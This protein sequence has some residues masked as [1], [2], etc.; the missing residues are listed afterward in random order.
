MTR[1][2]P[3]QKNLVNKLLS[4]QDVSGTNAVDI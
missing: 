4:Y 2:R 1:A 3:F